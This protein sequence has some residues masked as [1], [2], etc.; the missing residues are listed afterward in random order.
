MGDKARKLKDKASKL[1]AKGKLS[2]AMKFYQQAKQLAPDD[3]YI[4]QKIAE[5]FSR[6]GDIKSSIQEYQHLAGRHAA[7]GMFL[8]AIAINKIIL[9]LDPNHK[10]TQ[11]VLA[12]LY[13]KKR[14]TE[15]AT[16]V[17]LQMSRALPSS[18]SGAIDNSQS[19]AGTHQ[20]TMP[21]EPS[22]ELPGEEESVIFDISMAEGT[23]LFPPLDDIEIEEASEF[24]EPTLVNASLLPTIPLFSE[25]SSDEMVALIERLE[26]RWTKKGDRI[27]EEGE[28]GASM[29][30]MSQGKVDILRGTPPNE[31]TVAQLDEGSFF[32]EMALVS[33]APRLATVVAAED[34]LLLELDRET[35][36]ELAQQHPS[37][38][39]IIRE[40]HLQRLTANLMGSS[41]VFGAFSDGAR[42]FFVE[43]SEFSTV[44][45]GTIIHTQGDPAQRLFV[46]LRG[47]CEVLQSTPECVEQPASDFGEGELFG[48]QSAMLDQ[49]CA[50]TVRAKTNCVLLSLSPEALKNLFSTHEEVLFSLDELVEE[51][52]SLSGISPSDL[53]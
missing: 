30:V 36:D 48:V 20:E 10:E 27:I 15:T 31:V 1:A 7:D 23:G 18:M 3:L 35:L 17:A 50:S 46:V 4:R 34:G 6:T 45:A 51:R 42:R 9:S 19:Q 49:P 52:L 44:R 29:F 5:L 22:E 24:Y 26:L 53:I 21:Y 33:L 8:K 41:E 16:G 12:D 40:H 39:E 28:S 11:E 32:G 38:K 47:C 13:S 43:N 2:K 37:I 14:A 25:F